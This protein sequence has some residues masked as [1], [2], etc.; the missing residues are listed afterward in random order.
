MLVVSISFY[1]IPVLFS[2]EWIHHTYSF[3]L[4]GIRLVNIPIEEF[5]F[6]FLGGAFW[7]PFYEFWQGKKLIDK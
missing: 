3:V 4:S 5:I 1:I 2:R 7:G 6:W